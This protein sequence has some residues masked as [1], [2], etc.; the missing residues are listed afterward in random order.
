MSLHSERTPDATAVA[1]TTVRA[2]RMED[3][4][5]MWRVAR[6]SGTLDLN[7]SY[8]YA[9]FARDF[10]ATSRVAVAGGEVVGF[11]LG[12]RRPDDLSRLFIWQV[13]VDAAQRGR[14]VSGRMLDDL[15]GALRAADPSVGWLETTI[16]DDNLA[17]RGL[18]RSFAARWRAT[19]R[20][21]PLFDAAH[22]PDA[23][24]AEPLHLIGPL[25]TAAT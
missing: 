8:A 22:F 11:V 23:H 20:I 10:S 6:D 4:A 2:P 7:S 21:D 13:A 5:G 9:L 12:Y 25:D 14:G 18:F 19:E 24:D 3:G 16:T 15:V 1:R 17:S